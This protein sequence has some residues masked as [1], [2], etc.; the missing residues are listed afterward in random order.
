MA[1]SKTMFPTNLLTGAKYSAFWTSLLQDNY[2]FYPMITWSSADK[3]QR[4][5][6]KK[7]ANAVLCYTTRTSV[8]VTTLARNNHSSM[9]TQQAN[10]NL[11]CHVRRCQRSRQSGN[12]SR[13]LALWY[14]SVALNYECSFNLELWSSKRAETLTTNTKPSALQIVTFQ[15]SKRCSQKPTTSITTAASYIQPNKWTKATF[16][17][18]CNTILQSQKVFG[19]C[20]LNDISWR[21]I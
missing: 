15:P 3:F 6:K 5:H 10:N 20:H 7:Y 12:V 4:H 1:I 8:N 14:S 11:A 2:G 13:R 16:M 19:E 17:D 18:Y 21:R 9:N